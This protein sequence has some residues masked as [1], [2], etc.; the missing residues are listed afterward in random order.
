MANENLVSALR[1]SLTNEEFTRLSIA[2]APH[3]SLLFKTDLFN[4]DKETFIEIASL[5]P[6]DIIK[7]LIE[8]YPDNPFLKY[9]S[10]IVSKEKLKQLEDYVGDKTLYEKLLVNQHLIN[11]EEY[12]TLSTS[13]PQTFAQE[14]VNLGMKN[15][16]I[17]KLSRP[18]SYI[19][20]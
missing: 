15:S 2:L 20:K 18:Y 13:I 14:L 5:I 7:K 9:S 19:I 11:E 10:S 8:I 16:V 3:L 6:R 4:L 1:R 12:K 17:I